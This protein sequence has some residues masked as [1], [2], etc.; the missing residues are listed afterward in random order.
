MLKNKDFFFLARV[1]LRG[2]RS[3]WHPIIL[4]VT[5][6]QI[7]EER[8]PQRHHRENINTRRVQLCSIFCF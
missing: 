5:R 7:P 8:S 3:F 4:Q 6:R 1:H 2:L